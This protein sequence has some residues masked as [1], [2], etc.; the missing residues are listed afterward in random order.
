MLE[1]IRESILPVNLPFTIL[2]GVIAL[3]W[4]IGL[5]GLVDMEALDGVGGIEVDG[6]DGIDADAGDGVGEGADGGEDGAGS[7]GGFFQGILTII[8]A[9]DAPLIFVISLFSVFLW[10]FN[11]GGNH[12]FN[13]GFESGRAALLLIPVVI[14]AC[15]V[16]RLLVVPLRP[17]M[18][19]I[20]S[21]EKPAEIIGATGTVRSSRLD[22]EFGEVEIETSEKNLILRA[23]ISSAET[24]L[25]KGD[26]ILVVSKD[27]D[28]NVYLVRSLD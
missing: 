5:L 13:P 4:I 28:S 8:G 22:A 23:R 7:S 20:R 14:A 12:Y 24:T 1:L 11:I 16:T 9:S 6:L 15:V 26:H 10:A 3:Y 17:V 21:S 25:N 2:L 18:K 19:M 27:E